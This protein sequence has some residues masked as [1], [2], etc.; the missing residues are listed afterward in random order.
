MKLSVVIPAYNEEDYINI[1]LNSLSKQEFKN[2]E[3]V[4]CLNNCTDKT[5][6]VVSEFKDAQ[7]LNIKTVEESHKGVAFA[8]NAGFSHTSGDIIAS[9]DADTFYPPDWTKKIVEKFSKKDIDCL[10]G[11][12]Y[13]KSDS[14]LMRFSAKYLFSLFLKI[15]HFFKNYNLNGM[16]FAIRCQAFKQVGGFNTSWKSAEDVYIGVKLKELGK[17]VSFEKD[18]IVYTH[19]RR[20]QDNTASSLMHH[21]KNYINVFIRKKEPLNFKDIR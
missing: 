11:P 9:A 4:V 13:I 8:R 5:A 14:R 3:V 1:P 20:F 12:V 10:Y 19:D 16:N 6:E 18:L 15:S 21:V 17:K 2:F 7:K